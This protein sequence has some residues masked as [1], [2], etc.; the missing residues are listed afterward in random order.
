VRLV[1]LVE[2]EDH[3]CCRYRLAAYRTLF[4]QAGHD[5]ALQPLPRTTLRRL[6]IGSGLQSADAVIVQRKLLP[7]W[8]IGL[9]RRRVRRL[10]FDFDD[11]VWLRDS[12]ARRGFVD[13]KRA[14]RFQTMIRACDLVVAGNEF[15]AAEAAQ[16]IAPSRMII[17]PT[18]VEPARYPVAQHS[19]G[20]GVQLV[21]VGSEST[22]RGLARFTATLA[23]LGQTIPGL[24]L[25]LIC[26]R[27]L[28]IPHVTVDACLWRQET[29]AAELADA[30]IGISWV[31]DD[32]WSRGKCGLKILQ[33]QA[34]GLPV[35]TNPVG[36]HVA[37]VQDA[38]TGFTA[39]STEEWC[40][41]TLRL[42]GD[43]NLRR[44][45]GQNGRKQ[46]EMAY[47]VASGAARWLNA[48]N[49]LPG[50]LR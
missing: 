40:R 28:Q 4:A 50:I 24:R 15:L 19:R 45:L 49:R 48:L 20:Q 36:V 33:Y 35:I 42:A 2:S 27:F 26:D 25:K 11:A 21:W 6:S 14:H 9:L 38:V 17:I 10:I 18:C 37:M 29:E 8:A 5:L 30:D 31:P 43:Q 3:V 12:Y 7:P 34:A 13:A 47:S 23:A 46:V 32:P 16:H 22:L 39:V 41:A 44:Q 1:A